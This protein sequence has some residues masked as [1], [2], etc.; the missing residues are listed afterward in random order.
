MRGLLLLVYHLLF[1]LFPACLKCLGLLD[2]LEINHGFQ[3]FEGSKSTEL[4]P[5]NR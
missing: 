4:L 5:G 2:P 1:S 3:I